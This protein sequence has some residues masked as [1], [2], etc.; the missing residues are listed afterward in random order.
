MQ[1][2]EDN[3]PFFSPAT[4]TSSSEDEEQEVPEYVSTVPETPLNLQGAKNKLKRTYSQFF[5]QQKEPLWGTCYKCHDYIDWA[6][7]MREKKK[8]NICDKAYCGRCLTAERVN[9]RDY[10]D[11]FYRSLGV[12]YC[13][14]C[15]QHLISQAKRNRR[16]ASKLRQFR[17]LCTHAAVKGVIPRVR[18]SSFE[19]L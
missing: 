4:P 3:P 10:L 11:G 14:E 12:D 6:K 2:V 9:R 13:D 1:H 7:D 17:Q 19:E 8:C 5:E 16:E 18:S 15:L